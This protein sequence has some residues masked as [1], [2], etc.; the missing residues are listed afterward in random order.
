MRGP[1]YGV[2][3]PADQADMHTPVSI[4][5]AIFKYAYFTRPLYAER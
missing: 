3:V 5:T 1:I 2:Q 4:Q